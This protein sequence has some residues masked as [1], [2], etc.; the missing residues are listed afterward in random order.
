MQC[1]VIPGAQTRTETKSTHQNTS[2]DT[3]VPGNRGPGARDMIEKRFPSKTCFS[4]KR[5]F[6][7]FEAEIGGE[8][9]RA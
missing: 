4:R 3:W 9:Q 6:T 2:P 8:S 1:F 5:V 7:I